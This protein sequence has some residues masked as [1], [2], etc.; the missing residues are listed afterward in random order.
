V[1]DAAPSPDA[2]EPPADTESAQEPQ[3]EQ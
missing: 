2:G 3:E 1:A